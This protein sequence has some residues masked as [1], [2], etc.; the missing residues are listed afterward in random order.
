MIYIFKQKRRPEHESVNMAVKMIGYSQVI[1]TR[2]KGQ[3]ADKILV[4]LRRKGQ[5]PRWEQMSF[6]D[7]ERRSVM[8]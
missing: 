5:P 3:P 4:K 6:K 2:R 8:K 1:A 7:Y